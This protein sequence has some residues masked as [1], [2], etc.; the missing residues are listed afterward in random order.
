MMKAMATLR[1]RFFKLRNAVLYRPGG[2]RRL[3][4]DSVILRPRNLIGK[5]F[6]EVGSKTTIML[7]SRMEGIAGWEDKTYDTKLIFGNNVYIGRYFF[8]TVID[9]VEVGDGCVFSDYVYISDNSH[10]LNPQ[11][12]GIM[13]QALESKGPVKI[14]SH[15]FLGY[16]V[17]IMPGVTLG[18]W[19]VVG[20]NSVVTK[21]FPAYSMIAGSPAKLLKVYSPE[22]AAWVPA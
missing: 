1:T 22:K 5:R 13:A 20:T 19:C 12:G 3:G 11:G 2:L 21:S 7:G 6:I 9:R 10:G 14:G 8:V 4:Q 18:D 16:R 15:C 17:A